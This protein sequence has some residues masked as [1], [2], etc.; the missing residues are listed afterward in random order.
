[1]NKH[2][3]AAVLAASSLAAQAGQVQTMR[4]QAQLHFDAAGTAQSAQLMDTTGLPQ[5]FQDALR[6]SLMKVQINPKMHEGKPVDFKTGAIVFL[7]IDRDDEGAAKVDMKVEEF[8]VLPVE[9]RM[10]NLPRELAVQAAYNYKFKLS[11]MVTP[12]G[13][14][15]EPEI[16]SDEP[17]PQAVRRWAMQSVRAWQFVPQRVAGEAVASQFE[18]PYVLRHGSQNHWPVDFRGTPPMLRAPSLNP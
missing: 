14:C 5:G 2:L 15:L 8:T 10:L 7:A 3:L 18:M 1:M 9:R 6:A 4:L 13:R 16:Q 11:C 17:V 12:E